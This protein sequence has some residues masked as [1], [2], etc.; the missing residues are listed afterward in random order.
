M[1]TSDICEVKSCVKQNQ[2]RGSG[3]NPVDTSKSNHPLPDMIIELRK[4]D[5]NIETVNSNSTIDA[6]DDQPND[7]RQ[8][9]LG[10]TDEDI[11]D[12]RHKSRIE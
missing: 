9:V 3:S 5:E 10:H 2:Q 12:F 11:E 8:R 1:L 4:R 7:Y 6:H